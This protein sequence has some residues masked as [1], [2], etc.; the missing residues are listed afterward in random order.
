MKTNLG[1]GHGGDSGRFDRLKEVALEFAFAV[2]T[3]HANSNSD[4]APPVSGR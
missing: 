4:S 2:D 1:A 3:L